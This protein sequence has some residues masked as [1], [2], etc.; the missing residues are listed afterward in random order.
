MEFV[1]IKSDM[2]KPNTNS[3][4][5]ANPPHSILKTSSYQTTKKITFLGTN[6]FT[7]RIIVVEVLM[8]KILVWNKKSPNFGTSDFVDKNGTSQVEAA[9][10]SEAIDKMHDLAESVVKM[11][12]FDP[13]GKKISDAVCLRLFIEK[14]TKDNDK[15]S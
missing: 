2:S 15:E 4:A 13:D 14:M 7:G 8:Y 10:L 12:L 11:K 5:K 3:K 6:P 9:S 1:H